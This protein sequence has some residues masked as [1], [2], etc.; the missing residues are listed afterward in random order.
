M[1]KYKVIEIKESVFKNNDEQADLL[2]SDLKKDT[3][4][5]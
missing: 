1:E 5:Y 3:L 2:R 4:F